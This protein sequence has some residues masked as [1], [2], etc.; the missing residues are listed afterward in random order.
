MLVRAALSLFAGVLT[1]L[2]PCVLPFLPVIVGGS[3]A[4]AAKTNGKRMQ[5]R[6]YAYIVTLSL[7][8]SL[9]IFSLLLKASTV[10]LLIDPWIWT[11]ISGALVITLGLAM[12]FPHAWEK[13]E[14]TL[15]LSQ[16]SHKMLQS[17]RN[18]NNFYLRAILTGAALGPVFSSCSPTFVWLISQILPVSPIEGLIYLALYCMGLA[19]M[20]LAISLLGQRL[21]H[22]LK[23]ASS[24]D[25][26]FQKFVGIIFILVG[27]AII[28]GLDRQFQVW[29]VMHGPNLIQFEQSLLPRA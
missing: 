27:I 21:I 7:I 24:T 9:F 23:W 14:T 25:S 26:L 10:F 5:A 28:T 20:L 29:L 8:L 1:V 19:G 15:H 18:Q 22:R 11:F 16:H 13:V 6:R 4:S 12:V 3:V 2:A 17:A